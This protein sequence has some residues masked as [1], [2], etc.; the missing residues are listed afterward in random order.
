VSEHAKLASDPC[1]RHVLQLV[2]NVKEDRV[3]SWPN[4]AVLS[5]PIF[6]SPEYPRIWVLGGPKM[7][8][9]LYNV[10]PKQ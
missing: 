10:S 8:I 5:T 9:L 2:I 6:G 3:P 4:S 1:R 7:E